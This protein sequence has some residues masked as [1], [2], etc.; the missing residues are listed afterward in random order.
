MGGGWRTTQKLGRDDP[1]ALEELH[2][3]G[4]D[5]MGG[6][7]GV[8]FVKPTGQRG[9]VSRLFQRMKGRGRFD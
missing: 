8:P 2:L 1:F 9:L 6:G 4:N 3:G 5:L 7:K